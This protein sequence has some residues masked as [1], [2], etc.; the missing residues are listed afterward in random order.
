M[1]TSLTVFTLLTV[2][3][4]N[5]S[6][7]VFF[8]STPFEGHTGKVDSVAFSPDGK[9]IAS[10]SW[11][12]TV[13][14]WDV[15]ARE[16]IISLTGHTSPVYSIAI[17]P[18]GKMIAS[19]S[20]DRTIRLWDLDTHKNIAI[21]TGHKDAVSSLAFSPDGKMIASGSYDK[22]I[23]LWDVDTETS[24]KTF[25]EHQGRVTSVAFSL[26]GKIL[27]SGSW[28]N[29]IRLWDV[30]TYANIKTL[31]ETTGDVMSVVFSPDGKTFATGSE[32]GAI[33]LWDLETIENIKT[34]GEHAHSYLWNMCLAFSP[35]GKTIAAGIY[36]GS[37]RIW[38]IATERMIGVIADRDKK[39]GTVDSIA[40][41]PD[42]KTIA[43]GSWDPTVRLWHITKSFKITPYP[44]VSPAIGKQ[45][46]INI[47]ADTSP[48]SWFDNFILSFDE[49][50]LR[51]VEVKKGDL[52]YS[53]ATIEW[54]FY[55]TRDQDRVRFKS[56]FT[57]GKGILAKVTFEV[58]DVKESFIEFYDIGFVSPFFTYNGKVV[59]PELPSSAVVSINPSTVLSPAIGEQL[60]FNIDIVDGQNVERS[61]L[62]LDF[63]QSALKHISSSE[64][65]YFDDGVGNGNGTL[66]TVAFE[67]L[68]VKTSTVGI[69][70][71]LVAPNGFRYIP[72]FENA[73]I[74]EPPLGDVNRDGVVSI[75]DLVQVASSLGQQVSSGGNSADVN[76]DGVINIIDLV[77]V[78]GAINDAA[79]APTAWNIN[80]QTV[81]T[82]DQMQKW[83]SQAQNLDLSDTTSKKGIRFLENLLASLTPKRT[84]LLPNYPNPFNPETWIPYQLAEPA[85][86]NI[87]VYT[88]DG[89]VVRTLALGHQTVG[90]YHDKTRAAYWDG[91]NEAGDAVA[92]G[93]Y[94]YTLTAGKFKATRKMLILK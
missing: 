20:Y 14:L 75:L 38:D 52:V 42:G 40:F 74:I 64:S 69:S 35:D 23:R 92:S 37:I 56:R 84:A 93:V 32:K 86:V 41:S 81:F 24:V 34:F 45:F 83:V 70:G 78:A 88:S 47:E 31:N 67:V 33:R 58:V 66:E 28:D 9:M 53:S 43:T 17:S 60:I 6:A 55:A 50:A 85:D 87:S 77:T 79:A 80:L 49:S 22:T 48:K 36:W 4:L 61:E 21:L 72:T 73:E 7:R 10:G 5:T 65:S 2:L 29:T 39:M 54:E 1:K 11:D 68:D 25:T 18:D 13:R 59:P 27:A 82:R 15:A 94:F 71:F 62:T 91:K 57:G 44:I 26:D 90:I 12:K 76:E 89:A 16:E 3:T 8:H 63:D 19:G 30:N 51:F 46:T